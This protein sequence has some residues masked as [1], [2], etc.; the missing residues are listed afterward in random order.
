MRKAS[1]KKAKGIISQTVRDLRYKKV[2]SSQ[3]AYINNA[4]IIP[5]LS[6]MLQLTKLSEKAINRIHQPIIQLAKLKSG[7]ARTTENCTMEHK[8]LG[9]CRSLQKEIMM[10]QISS[11]FLRINK[12]DSLGDLT[13]LR[14]TQGCQMAEL[15]MNIWEEKIGV[16][17]E[18]VWK[19]NL[20]CRTFI[21]AKLAGI[22]I[23]SD[24]KLWQVVG[25]GMTIRQMVKEKM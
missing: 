11:L 8:D 9:S 23:K 6:Y 10:K 5:K 17:H 16:E 4:V 3:I 1:E 7:I 12:R 15:T 20:A 21:K 13:R 22:N 18:Q 25:Y 24:Q 2:T 14:I 19:N